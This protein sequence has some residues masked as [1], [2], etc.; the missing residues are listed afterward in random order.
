MGVM[1]VRLYCFWQPSEPTAQC[2]ISWGI[3]NGVN[4][5]IF[6]CMG[7]FS[8]WP[9]VM[10]VPQ[11]VLWKSVRTMCWH[12]V[13]NVWVS[14]LCNRENKKLIGEHWLTSPPLT[15]N[16]CQTLTW[17]WSL[18]F[19]KT[20]AYCYY[21]TSETYYNKK[22]MSGKYTVGEQ[23]VFF[24]K[25]MVLGPRHWW[26]MSDH[27]LRSQVYVF[28]CFHACLHVPVSMVASLLKWVWCQVK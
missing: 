26:E 12:Y 21:L 19:A 10:T 15:I 5:N 7:N 24:I 22:G 18:P 28:V 16:A 13:Y 8:Y 17:G 27:S 14:A 2:Q 9:E 25:A 6:W 3:T 11:E 20:H 23:G 4:Y 1:P